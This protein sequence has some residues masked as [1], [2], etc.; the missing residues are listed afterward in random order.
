MYYRKNDD[1]ETSLSTTIS[2][3]IVIGFLF[4]IIFIFI[5]S[6]IIAYFKYKNQFCDKVIDYS[7]DE[8]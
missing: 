7:L 3:L 5:S 6:C 4:I 2:T 1:S 8:I